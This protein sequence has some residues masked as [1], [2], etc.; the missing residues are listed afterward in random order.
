MNERGYLWSGL[1]EEI[2]FECQQLSEPEALRL[3]E[4]AARAVPGEIRYRMWSAREND[5]LPPEL[6]KQVESMAKSAA[7]RA[8]AKQKE[9]EAAQAEPPKPRKKHKPRVAATPTR[10]QRSHEKRK[11]MREKLP[12]SRE[13]VTHHF[14]IH[15]RNPNPVSPD[16]NSLVDVDGYIITGCYPDGRVGEIF[17]RIGK[18]GSSEAMIDEWAKT[19]SI[20]LQSGADFV[21]LCMKH[22]G[23][24]F[25]P[26]G[27]TASKLVPRCTSIV[28]YVCRFL[29]KTYAPHVLAVAV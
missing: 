18:P 27:G 1:A 26:S 20:A 10:Y 16:D 17:V 15:A 7:R 29:L 9:T 11:A 23:T 13:G 28:D 12:D 6:R 19:F 25:E 2:V 22:V 3:E 14:T 8:W 21:D 4:I 5:R 24:R